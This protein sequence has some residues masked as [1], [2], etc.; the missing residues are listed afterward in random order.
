MNLLYGGIEKNT[1][2]SPEDG[3]FKSYVPESLTDTMF[4]DKTVRVSIVSVKNNYGRGWQSYRPD[5]AIRLGCS[6]HHYS[7]NSVLGFNSRSLLTSN[8]QHWE[9]FKRRRK[10]VTAGGSIGNYRWNNTGRLIYSHDSV[11]GKG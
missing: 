1:S 5:F 6:L 7:S 3:A 2:Y 8:N 9:Q 10:L 11:I 4:A